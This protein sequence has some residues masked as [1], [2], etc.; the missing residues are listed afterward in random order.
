MIGGSV[1]MG[2]TAVVCAPALMSYCYTC[3]F[4]RKKLVNTRTP[5]LAASEV[6]HPKVSGVVHEYAD[7]E[8]C[9]LHLARAGIDPAKKCILF[10]HG[11]PEFWYSWRAQLE[12]FQ[13]EYEVLAIDMPG[14][15]ASGKLGSASKYVTS[16]LCKIIAAAIT[17][18]G[19]ESCLVVGHDWGA[20]IASELTT[21]YPSR[22]EKLV[23]LANAPTIQ[24]TK[25]DFRQKLASSYMF[26]FNCPWLPERIFSMGDFAS[27]KHMFS[28]PP[29]EMKRKTMPAEEVEHYKNAFAMPGA[30]TGSLNY[31]RA[32]V[33]NSPILR[34]NKLMN[35][36]RKINPTFQ[37]PVLVVWGDSDTALLPNLLHS[38]GKVA[39]NSVVRV[40]P[41]CSHWVQQDAAEEVNQLMKTFFENP[42]KVL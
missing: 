42:S 39:P 7:C 22:V 24:F 16:N 36:A 38:I 1:V 29:F 37:M 31:Y 2:I 20:A 3:I 13:A 21:M 41:N 11:F 14:Y 27:L 34:Q 25:A 32:A 28:K 33:W 40:L 9:R 4:A 19:R 10:I 23:L 12:A 30:L 18:I 17:H 8:G 5:K 6:E 35:Q 15:N 26:F